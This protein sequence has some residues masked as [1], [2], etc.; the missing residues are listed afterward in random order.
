MRDTVQFNEHAIHDTLRA[1]AG[2]ALIAGVL[3]ASFT[4]A[5]VGAI[6][7]GGLMVAF[8]VG[9]VLLTAPPHTGDR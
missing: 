2:G 1:A 7:A 9:T 5:I 6:T 8:I 3:T 4:G